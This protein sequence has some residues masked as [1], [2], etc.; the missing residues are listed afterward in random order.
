MFNEAKLKPLPRR[1]QITNWL[2]HLGKFEE[3]IEAAFKMINEAGF[4]VWFEYF[5]SKLIKEQRE[6][7]PLLCPLCHGALTVDTDNLDYIFYEDSL[8]GTLECNNSF[9]A[10]LFFHVPAD[11]KPQPHTYC[12]F[13]AHWD[14]DVKPQ[15][16]Y[17]WGITYED[18]FN[19]FDGIFVSDEDD[20]DEP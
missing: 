19:T 11:L 8:T 4:E 18:H 1:E 7:N 6:A 17:C 14:L 12:D 13:T 15:G 16:G 2:T 3:D 5:T 20:D 10:S 9:R